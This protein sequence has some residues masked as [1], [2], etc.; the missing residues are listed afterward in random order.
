M[1]QIGYYINAVKNLLEIKCLLN[2]KS[3]GCF[4]LFVC[5]L[6]HVAS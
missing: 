1:L 6:Q 4:C 3:T 2:I 5:F